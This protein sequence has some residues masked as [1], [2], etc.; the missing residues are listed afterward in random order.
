MT[1]E[2]TLEMKHLIFLFQNVTILRQMLSVLSLIF[3]HFKISSDPFHVAN[4]NQNKK[5]IAPPGVVCHGL[6]ENA[7]QV[8]QL[9]NVTWSSN[10]IFT[11]CALVLIFHGTKINCYYWWSFIGLGKNYVIYMYSSIFKFCNWLVFISF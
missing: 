9:Y 2:S 10:H 8:N 7:L 1:C 3:K 4:T 6:K 11:V 5:K